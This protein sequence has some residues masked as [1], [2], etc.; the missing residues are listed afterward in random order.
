MTTI[1][2][3]KQTHIITR[4][5]AA[6]QA[7]LAEF[8]A[9]DYTLYQP[10]IKLNAYEICPLT[11]MVLFRTPV[12]CEATVI[13]HGKAPAGDITHTFPAEKEHI[14]PIYGLMPIMTIW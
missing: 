9:G 11:A 13:V 1:T 8:R 5:A 2:Y 3:T 12:A 4:Q 6:E 10:L 7:F 14:L